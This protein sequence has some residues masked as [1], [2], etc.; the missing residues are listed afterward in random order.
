M[1]RA[2]RIL[3]FESLEEGSRFYIH[4]ISADMFFKYFMSN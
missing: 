3:E 2:L 1:D 4:N